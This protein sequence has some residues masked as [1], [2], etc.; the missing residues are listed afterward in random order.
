[1]DVLSALTGSDP[2][3]ISSIVSVLEIKGFVDF[4]MGKVMAI[5]F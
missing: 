2:L 3:L 5:K 4:S 1:M